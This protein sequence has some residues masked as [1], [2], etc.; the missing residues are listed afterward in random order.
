[1]NSLKITL[2][3]IVLGHYARGAYV[4]S[5][6][7]TGE[8][9]KTGAKVLLAV[10]NDQQTLEITGRSTK[11]VLG[12]D[13][14]P[15]LLRLLGN[16]NQWG[17]SVD[18]T[19]EIKSGLQVLAKS[20]VQK[21]SCP[22]KPYSGPLNFDAIARESPPLTYPGN[23]HGR[24]WAQIDGKRFFRHGSILETN[25]AMRG[26]DCTT[27]PM[28]IFDCYPNMA[29]QY[30]TALADALGAVRCDMEQK[31]E[32]ELKQ[33]FSGKG[34]VGLYFM[35]S[36]GHVVLVHN[37]AIH[38]FTYGGYKRSSAAI[39]GGYHHAA[40]GLWWVRRLNRTLPA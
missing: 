26:F 40:Q 38:E 27:F 31:K 3:P 7:V 28:A 25:N 12:A 2:N 18:C 9:P 39:W 36:A 33:F 11:D 10:G 14:L 20:N 4:I 24:V 8:V 32:T 17:G 6:S 13:N 35:W 15:Q 37:A 21:L 30:G 29:G 5:Y 22:V 34:S 19:V 16:L 1:M 23:G